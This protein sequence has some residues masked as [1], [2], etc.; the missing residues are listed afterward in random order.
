VTPSQ[1]R[2]SAPS[3]ELHVPATVV[4]CVGRQVWVCSAETRNVRAGG[5]SLL[6]E[7]TCPEAVVDGDVVVVSV[8]WAGG[9]RHLGRI[10]RLEGDRRCLHLMF[11]KP[12]RGFD[13]RWADAVD[14]ALVD[15][16]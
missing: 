14:R 3:V 5:V 11:L 7:Q 13:P 12:A 6:L 8:D 10:V 16:A 2:R 15:A 1:D 4:A 9:H